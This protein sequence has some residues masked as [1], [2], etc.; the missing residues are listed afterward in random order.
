MLTALTPHMQEHLT[1]TAD[2]SFKFNDL[3][4]MFSFSWQHVHHRYHS[5]PIPSDMYQ[6][7]ACTAAQEKE[8]EFLSNFSTAFSLIR[9]FVDKTMIIQDYFSKSC[10]HDGAG[11]RPIKQIYNCF[12]GMKVKRFQE[13]DHIAILLH[14]SNHAEQ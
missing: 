4:E 6:H 12:Y 3:L 5:T 14:Q 9:D 10:H 1:L 7:G 13:C 8:R 2:G 11:S